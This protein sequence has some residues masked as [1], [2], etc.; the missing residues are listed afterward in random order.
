M[1]EAQSDT[2]VKVPKSIRVLF[3]ILA[4]NKYSDT[5]FWGG[6]GAKRI[7]VADR[8]KLFREVLPLYYMSKTWCLKR[9]CFMLID[10]GFEAGE[11]PEE[12]KLYFKHKVY[13]KAFAETFQV[14]REEKYIEPV[15]GQIIYRR[16]G[17]ITKKIKKK[18]SEMSPD[19][20]LS[21]EAMKQF[22]LRYKNNTKA[23]MD[24]IP[25]VSCLREIIQIILSLSM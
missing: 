11:I 12:N 6:K 15:D 2:S 23:F 14:N 9:F 16:F 18:E 25:K 1:D 24:V 20:L 22:T 10:R 13:D 4:E 8:E 5:I 17:K 7:Y 21:M 19:E 3:Q